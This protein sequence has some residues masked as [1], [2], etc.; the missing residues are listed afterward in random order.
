M[1]RMTNDR[2]VSDNL[3]YRGRVLELHTVGV[4]MEDGKVMQR[5]LVHYN[6]AAVILPVL[7]DGR[8]VLIRNYRFSVNEYLYELPA[9]MLEV[10]EDPL[11]CARREL[12]EETGY[13]AG[14]LEKLS[15]FASSP[16]VSDEIMHAFLATELTDGTQELEAHEDIHVE[17]FAPQE[18][19]RM[20]SDQTIRDG[21]TIAIL[22]LYWLRRGEL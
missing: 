11:E 13:R 7:D 17:V 14:K 22:C 21:K 10:G 15:S 16:G 5:E 19:R 8:I 12:I 2:I 6:G 3:V 9:G 18:V 4:R 20:L 1:R